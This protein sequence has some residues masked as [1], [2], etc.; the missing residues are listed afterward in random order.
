MIRLGQINFLRILE[1]YI[2]E[3][4]ADNLIAENLV[5]DKVFEKLHL[6]AVVNRKTAAAGTIETG[7]FWY[8]THYSAIV[9][10]V[11]MAELVVTDLR[12]Q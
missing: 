2:V 4:S 6:L 8:K 1:E 3:A 12:Q 11:A 9:D 5:A 10:L 7:C